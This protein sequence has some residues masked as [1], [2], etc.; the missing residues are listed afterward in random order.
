MLGKENKN[1]Y[2]SPVL[3]TYLKVLLV[4]SFEKGKEHLLF[5]SLK[6]WFHWEGGLM[7]REKV[8]GKTRVEKQKRKIDKEENSV[9]CTKGQKTWPFLC[10]GKTKF[11]KLYLYKQF[12]SLNNILSYRQ[13]YN[14]ETQF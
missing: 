8:S 9:K 6:K 7:E 13:R 10:M 11:V 3:C 5:F 12:Y 4:V 2:T 14:Y 1:G